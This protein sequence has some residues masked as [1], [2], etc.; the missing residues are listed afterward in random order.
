[1]CMNDRTRKLQHPALDRL[2]ACSM[3]IPS[4]KYLTRT[5]Y[6]HHEAG[7]QLCV[8]YEFTEVLKYSSVIVY[9]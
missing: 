2:D 6:V 5:T 9:M 3:T 7:K 8:T 4:A 1:M